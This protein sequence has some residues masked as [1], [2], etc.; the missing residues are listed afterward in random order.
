[1]PLSAA[2]KQPGRLE[3][4]FSAAA[5]VQLEAWSDAVLDTHSLAEVSPNRRGDPAG[6]PYSQPLKGIG[7]KRRL[8]AVGVANVVVLHAVHQAG[9][10]S[11]GRPVI[12]KR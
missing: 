10:V 12:P 5:E 1:M 3:E 6:R 7:V 2:E 8:A 9:C 4:H 11:P